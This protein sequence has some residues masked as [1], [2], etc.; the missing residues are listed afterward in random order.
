MMIPS[1]VD[2]GSSL[3]VSDVLTVMCN[4]KAA[5]N[6]LTPLGTPVMPFFSLLFFLFLFRNL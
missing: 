4:R 2:S 3:S 1:C 6:P 5:R